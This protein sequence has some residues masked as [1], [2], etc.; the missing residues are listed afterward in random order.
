MNF[1][2]G[3]SI[4]GDGF[5]AGKAHVRS[6]PGC[7]ALVL[8]GRRGRVCG[9]VVWRA[10]PTDSGLGTDTGPP[11]NTHT[12]TESHSLRNL[13]FARYLGNRVTLRLVECAG[14]EAEGWDGE[15]EGWESEGRWEGEGGDGKDELV[16]A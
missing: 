15:E 4:G 1:L 7:P 13:A 3:A 6:V 9:Q 14:E 8:L 16:Y 11:R 5:E 10:L 12:H 2:R